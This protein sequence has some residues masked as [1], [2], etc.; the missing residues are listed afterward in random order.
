MSSVPC[1]SC[2]LLKD[3]C[4][5]LQKDIAILTDKVNYLSQLFFRETANKS[6]QTVESTQSDSNDLLA[7]NLDQSP[8]Y[9]AEVGNS[10]PSDI[11]FDIFQNANITSSANLTVPDVTAPLSDGTMSPFSCIPGQPLANISLD[12]LDQETEFLRL[13]SNRSTFFI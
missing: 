11:L 8:V 7:V 3:T 12:T 9:E 13:H 6:T 1:N 2:E 4:N 5:K 10:N